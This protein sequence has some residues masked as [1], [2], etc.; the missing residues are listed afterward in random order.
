MELYIVGGEEP[1]Q[2]YGVGG[3]ERRGKELSILF[4]FGYD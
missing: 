2:P 4:V 1:Y 3:E